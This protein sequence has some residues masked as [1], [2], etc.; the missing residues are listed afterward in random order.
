MII[1]TLERNAADRSIVSCK[2][3]GHADFAEHGSD[4]VCAGVST[5]L[6]GT[7]NAV[8]TLLGI[9]MAHSMR[10]GFLKFRVPDSVMTDKD[11][12]DKLQLLLE[13]MLVMLQTIQSKY[14]DYITIREVTINS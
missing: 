14:G 8:E 10:S 9:E 5:I 1:V 12:R 4:I 13:S 2:S 7:F 6:V 3:R 11:V